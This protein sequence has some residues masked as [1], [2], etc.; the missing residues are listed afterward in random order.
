[1]N[2]LD[3]LD[4]SKVKPNSILLLRAELDANL[5]V[6]AIQK[7]R[8]VLDDAGLHSVL[9]MMARPDD[10]LEEM[11]ERAMNRHGWFRKVEPSMI[12]LSPVKVVEVEINKDRKRVWVN[13]DGKCVLRCS[14]IKNLEVI[15]RARSHS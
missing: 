13:V 7:L 1:M 11:D 6:H 10:S 4:L 8:K 14:Q 2:D 9:V 3:N 5:R 15:N 12:D